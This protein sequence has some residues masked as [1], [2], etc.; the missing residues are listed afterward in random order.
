MELHWRPC[1]G[2]DS[3]GAAGRSPLRLAGPRP[4]RGVRRAPPHPSL[5]CPT[6]VRRPQVD[7]TF[8]RMPCAWLSL[9]AMDVSG[10]LHLDVVGG[11]WGPPT[12]AALAGC[13]GLG[14]WG[15]P[16]ARGEV[17]SAPCLQ[18]LPNRRPHKPRPHGQ[19]HDIYKQ[20]LAANGAPLSQAERHVLAPPELKPAPRAPELA[21]GASSGGAAGAVDAPA[22][23]AA[24]AC[25]SCYGAE[26]AE[27][28]CCNTCDEVSGWPRP[29]RRLPGSGRAA[30]RPL[31]FPTAASLHCP[32]QQDAHPR[33]AVPQPHHPA[34]APVPPPPPPRPPPPAPPRRC[35]LLTSARAG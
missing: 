4:G 27:H 33:P 15:P 5:H 1:G 2:A 24:A 14:Q 26:D 35:A 12:A 16:M 18:A 17:R 9:D 13:Q 6:P 31:D 20:R 21:A 25:G 19:D 23:A 8:P 22:A 3:S 10:E 11:G 28:P 32:S 29:P 30:R 34:P 7:V